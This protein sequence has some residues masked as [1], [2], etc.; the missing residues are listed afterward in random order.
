MCFHLPPVVLVGLQDEVDGGL[1]GDLL[2][3][4]DL[5]E[6]QEGDIT[7]TVQ[8]KGLEAFPYL[9]LRETHSQ[10]LEH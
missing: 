5:C 3:P 8:V 4:Q 9:L 2:S 10:R 1:T 7:C 6:L